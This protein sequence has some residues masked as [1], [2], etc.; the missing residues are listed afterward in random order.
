MA[1]CRA[2]NIT[3]KDL[4]DSIMNNGRALEGMPFTLIKEMEDIA[5]DLE[6][7][8]WVDE[9]RFWPDLASVLERVEL[10]IAKLPRII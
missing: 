1:Q 3:G 4:S 6:I 7:A 5:E 2:H 10:W 9:D 8:D